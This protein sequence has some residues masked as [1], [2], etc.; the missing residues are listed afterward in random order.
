MLLKICYDK[1][2][3]TNIF[4]QLTVIKYKYEYI[5]LS[6]YIILLK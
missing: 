5:I 2:K 1:K 3:K 6:A 4:Y